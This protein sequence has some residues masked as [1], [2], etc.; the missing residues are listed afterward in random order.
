[1]QGPSQNR[2]HIEGG[3][4]FKSMMAINE[5]LAATLPPL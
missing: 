2:C 3:K 4:S 1:M 5:S